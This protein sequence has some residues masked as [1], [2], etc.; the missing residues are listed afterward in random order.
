MLVDYSNLKKKLITKEDPFHIHQILGLAALFS[1]TYRYSTSLDNMGFHN[2]IWVDIAT[3]VLHLLL[4]LSSLIFHVLKKRIV[5]TPLVIYEEY[6]LHAIIFTMRGTSVMLFS[7]AYTHLQQLCDENIIH[8]LLLSIVLL[9]HLIADSITSNYG[10]H[11]V[12]AV[13]V[14]NTNHNLRTSLV[15]RY[16][17]SFYQFLA[18]ASHLHL[19]PHLMELGFNTHIAI[20]S[21]AF[22]M[23]LRRKGIIRAKTHGVIYTFCLALSIYNMCLVYNPTYFIG[24]VMIAFIMRCKY[25]LNKYYIWLAYGLLNSPLSR[26]YLDSY[27][28]IL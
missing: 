6:R 25:G 24:T 7:H 21:S 19:G 2:N 27:Y 20:Q 13:R 1:F 22:M 4:S 10:T 11:G 17:Y 3:I 12:T 18:I 26:Q 15:V 5:A 28:K 9:H 14:K 23:T 8:F 16:L